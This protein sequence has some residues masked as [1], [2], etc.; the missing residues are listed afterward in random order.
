MWKSK[1]I[2]WVVAGLVILT[3]LMGSGC[4]L[5]NKSPEITSLTPSAT[6]VGPGGSCTVT[7][8]ASD[9]DEDDT[10][11]YAWAVTGGAISGTGN[12]V[13]W[14]A[15]A[16]EGT[17]T[18]SVTVSDGEGGEASES[19]A[20]EVTNTPPVIASLTPSATNVLPSGSCTVTCTASDAD[21]DI[22]T[23][24][25]TATGGAISGTGNSVTWTAPT[26]EGTYTISVTVS[27]GKGGT[28]SES[29]AIIVEMRFGS[30]DI[31]S[32]P[33]GA[34]VYLDGVDTGNITPY[35][36]TNA[37]P[38]TYTIKLEL[39]HYKNRQALVTVNAD[40][41]TYIN[42]SLNYASEQTITIQPDATAGK[43]AGVDTYYPNQNYEIHYQLGA[44]H[45]TVDTCRA[46]LQFNL[47]SIPA[48]AVIVNARL[49]LYYYYTDNLSAALIGAYL[50][51][52]AWNESTIT[53][54]N[55]PA[56]VTTPEY[57][58]NVPAL[59]TNAFIYWYISNMVKG[60]WDGSIL[61]YGVMLKDYDES[62]IE[63]WKGFYSSDWGTASQRP[64]LIVTYFDPT[65]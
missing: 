24:A 13:T 53:W 22:L 55:Q 16:T 6:T 58:V 5:F 44:G 40:E 17:Y 65:S 59:A 45:G 50:V 15:P 11:T 4:G 61:N 31:N 57:T 19:C 62:T 36:I 12:S 46:Y 14:T 8:T 29:C 47:A 30:I 38:G 48:N 10:L 26:T 23:Y 25:W 2:K 63:A 1:G 60:W 21:G 49:G 27:D 39:Y 28:A 56:V 42:W 34:T 52:G 33:A 20:I 7:C 41:T 3:M 32:S 43:D 37:P 64:V 9:P 54:N 18:I 51:P 35:V